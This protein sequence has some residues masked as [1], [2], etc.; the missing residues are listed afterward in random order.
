MRSAW[1]VILL[2]YFTTAIADVPDGPPPAIA[3]RA[4]LLIE[5][6]TGT[7]LAEHNADQQLPPASLTK[8]MT[9]YVLFGDLRAGRL[10]LDEPVTVS[11]EAARLPGARMF[12]TAGEVVSVENLLQGMLVQSGND[13]T[14]ALV[15]HINGNQ[16]RFVA[17]MNA[18]AVRLGLGHTRF[19]NAGGLHRPDHYSSARDLAQLS[20]ALRRDYPEYRTWFARKSFTWAGIAQPNR[21]RLLRDPT[22]DGLKTGHTEAA[23][24]NLVASSERNGMQ[25]IAVLLGTDSETS[26]ASAGRRLLDYGFRHYETRVVHHAGAIKQLPVWLGARDTV[27]LGINDDLRLTLRRNLFASLT[28]ELS[29][30]PDATAPIRRGQGFGHLRVRQD[31]QVIAD[32]P[33]VA[34][35]DVP[36]GNLLKRSGDRLRRWFRGQN[37]AQASP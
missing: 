4:F 20:L 7:V 19:I 6:Q 26:R 27:L 32:Q 24:F 16:A 2:A 8:L 34:L 22:V 13:A 31:N 30:P 1:L 33:L 9:A 29:V 11:R 36:N 3:A 35:E 18:E 15:E 25:L 28:T 10:R 14:R 37:M 12:L 23:G 21:N 5:S 17:R